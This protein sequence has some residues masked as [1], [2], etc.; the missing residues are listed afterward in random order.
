M[1]YVPYYLMPKHTKGFF[2]SPVNI[3]VGHMN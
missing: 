3:F 1:F 2:I